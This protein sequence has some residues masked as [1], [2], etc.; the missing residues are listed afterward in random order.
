M[1]HLV[2]QHTAVTGNIPAAKSHPSASNTLHLVPFENL[3][4]LVARHPAAVE[5]GWSNQVWDPYLPVLLVNRLASLSTSSLSLLKG[6]YKRSV[7]ML[8]VVYKKC[9]DCSFCLR[10]QGALMGGT[11]T[12]CH[13]CC[14]IG[15]SGL[16]GGAL[17][18]QQVCKLELQQQHAPS[19][20]NVTWAIRCIAR[21]GVCPAL[22]KPCKAGCCLLGCQKS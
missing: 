8:W 22:A 4:N 11:Q 1:V 7:C 20:H 2:I 21:Y 18:D 14:A 5:V 13:R 3:R 17:P 9:Y 16:S 6:M 15:V 12:V 10:N 19:I